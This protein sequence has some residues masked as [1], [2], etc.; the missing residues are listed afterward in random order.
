MYI[1]G[2]M[3]FIYREKSEKFKALQFNVSPTILSMDILEHY[4][5]LFRDDHNILCFAIWRDVFDIVLV[6]FKLDMRC[7]YIN[8]ESELV[9]M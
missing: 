6:M 8:S 7:N 4:I 5:L 9:T 1:V 2:D 3:L